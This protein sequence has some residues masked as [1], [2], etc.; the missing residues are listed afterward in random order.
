MAVPVCFDP[1]NTSAPTPAPETAGLGRGRGLGRGTQLNRAVSSVPE[2]HACAART[3]TAPRRRPALGP[4]RKRAVHRSTCSAVSGAARRSSPPLPPPRAGSPA[5][6]SDPRAARP[7]RAEQL[8]QRSS[9]LVGGEVRVVLAPQN[10]RRHPTEA[11][12]WHDLRH[13]LGVER[14]RGADELRPALLV[15]LRRRQDLSDKLLAEG[16]EPADL[17]LRAPQ[18]AAHGGDGQLL[19]HPGERHG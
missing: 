15:G 13:L 11:E 10:A 8:C 17:V 14:A 2:G 7:A 1:V 9:D 3:P 12:R 5:A 6:R 18:G 4:T 19:E 16:F